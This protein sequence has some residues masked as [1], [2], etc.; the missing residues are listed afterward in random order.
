MDLQKSQAKR[1]YA[2]FYLDM[3]VTEIVIT[4]GVSKSRISESINYGLKNLSKKLK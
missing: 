3:S 1:I 2:H 4:E